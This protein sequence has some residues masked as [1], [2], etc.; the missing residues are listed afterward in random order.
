MSDGREVPRRVFAPARLAQEF[1]RQKTGVA[2][3]HMEALHRRKPK[4]PKRA[5]SSH[6]EDHLLAQPVALIAAV[7]K[8][9][10]LAI[11]RSIFL[12]ARIQE[13]EWDRVAC[14]A[15]D[16]ILPSADGDRPSLDRHVC[17]T[18]RP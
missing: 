4:P 3:V 9:R 17:H 5:H 7:E 10:Q 14:A 12:D 18:G 13:E 15:P 6:A 2:F 1:E 16:A 8:R 11:P